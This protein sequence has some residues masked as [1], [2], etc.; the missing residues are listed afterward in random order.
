M[1]I[2]M[3]DVPKYD[4]RKSY[5]EQSVEVFQFWEQEFRKIK[6]GVVIG[7]YYIHPWMYFHTNFFVTP[8]PTRN[9]FGQ[10]EEIL[11]TPTLDDNF[12]F[13]LENYAEAERLRKGIGVFG[14][15]GS[16][17]ST[18]LASNMTWI[19]LIKPNGVTTI[20]GGDK[21]DLGDITGLIL[22]AIDNMCPAMA[23][24]T[25]K[26]DVDKEIQFGM[27]LK[28]GDPI[29]HSRIKIINADGG[30]GESKSEKGAGGSP[31][32]FIL[33]E[34]LHEDSIVYYEDCE[35]PI[36]DVQVGDF[37]F[38]ADGE[39]TEVK[40]KINPGVVD[41]WKFTLSDGREVISSANHRWYVQHR[42]RWITTTTAQ[43]LGFVG[44]IYLPEQKVV[45]YKDKQLKT[46]YFDA[47]LDKYSQEDL[48]SSEKNRRSFMLG[49]RDNSLHFTDGT[50]VT[51]NKKILED[52]VKTARS[53][54]INY[55][56]V[57][58]TDGWY[59]TKR[60]NEAVYIKN[61]EYAGKANTFCLGVSNK[62]EM[63]ITE[64][65]IPTKNCGKYN[66]L[67]I[68]ESATP[69]FTMS[70]GF[71][72]VPFL[73]GT[74]G[75]AQL[76]ADAKKVM[77]NP[78]SYNLIP[79]D[80]DKLERVVDPEQITW[81]G[82]KKQKFAT[83]MPGQMSYRLD[84]EKIEKPFSEVVGVDHPDLKKITM[85]VT[86]WEK[87]NNRLLEK[88]SLAVDE[89][90]RDKE[91]M[92]Y[93]RDLDDIFLTKGHNPFPKSVI[94]KRIQY[95]KDTGSSGASIEIDYDNGAFAMN[96]S[97][98]QI[99]QQ[100]YVGGIVDAPTQLFV[101]FPK[102][103]IPKY[104]NIAGMDHYKL[105]GEA[106]T[107]SFGAVYVLK[108]RN[109]KLNQPCELIQASY[110]ARPDRHRTFNTNAEKLLK[111]FNAECNLESLDL[112]FQQ[113]LDGKGIAEDFLCPAFSFSQAAQAG[114][115][116]S[117][118]RSRFGLYPT[119]GNKKVRMD[120]LIEWCK[121]EHIVGFDELGNAIIKLSVEFID[122]IQLLQ[123]MVDYRKGGNFD[124]LDAFSHA[125]ILAREY[126]KNE[127]NPIREQK[128]K[129]Y[130]ENPNKVKRSA[131]S[132]RRHSAYRR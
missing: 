52:Y 112:S 67:K 116:N 94:L 11:K 10:V 15:R 4:Y 43:M 103:S 122:D 100:Y 60:H 8:I 29:I 96:F 85:K 36:K 51:Q 26:R 20:T 3:T 118:L 42:N 71:K 83:Y 131:Y 124:R 70:D 73:S 97:D 6:E 14:T 32:G 84:V 56:E 49:V 130:V 93:P 88:L 22:Q 113:H 119:T 25:L 34:A 27:R 74:S 62:D 120:N 75:N 79:M 111:A 1:F 64:N 129:K 57:K 21:N 2:N 59:S 110:V 68:W 47:A 12:L 31:V 102:E 58:D 55:T 44:K 54:G 69:A 123:E 17:K 46:I 61:I 63:F 45:Q 19:N 104:E 9:S 99:T 98:K 66:F 117:S 41:T 95:L 16:T 107:G 132:S 72:L 23:L 127:V 18:A 39:L 101:D 48:R 78:E 91:K 82:T 38:G 125:L 109:Q 121:E 40:S 108:R 92:Y 13:I 114:K 37:I 5:H 86:D 76:S 89:D 28:N 81:N 80:Y 50:V 7:G 77:T 106:E 87:A 128:A 24:P 105:D 90:A 53:L 65:F 115:A 33:D 126:D 30:K 35:K